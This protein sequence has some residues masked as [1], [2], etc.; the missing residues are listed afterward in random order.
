M[1]TH[2]WRMSVPTLGDPC[3]ALSTGCLP[4][5]GA[6]LVS[7]SMYLSPTPQHYRRHIQLSMESLSG[8]IMGLY[9]RSIYP[10]NTYYEILN[11]L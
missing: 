2:C 5:S 9:I 4:S 6:P 7:L 3:N 11:G 1:S 10:L 8:L